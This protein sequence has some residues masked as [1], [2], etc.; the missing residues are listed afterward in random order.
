MDKKIQL[1]DK[2]FKVYLPQKDI[3][4][5]IAKVA[6]Q[7]NNDYKDCEDI[8]VLLCVLNGSVMFCGELMKHL[9]FDLELMSIRV[10]SYSGTES[11]QIKELMGFTGDIKGKRVIICEDI[12]DTGN[13]IVWL[14]NKLEKE[15][16]RDVK[17]CSMLLKPEVYK[18]D[19]KLDYI[20]KEIPN[21]FIVGYGL[22]YDQLGRNEKDI[23]VL[24]E[25]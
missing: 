11:G 25:N 12:I 7:L 3:E 10:S 16:A 2:T 21:K 15:G 18:K 13:T 6:E 17:I 24:D 4:D 1:H 19:V 5:S 14:K 9:S 8:P 20:A 22:D 23:Y